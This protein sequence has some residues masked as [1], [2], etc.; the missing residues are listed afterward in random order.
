MRF[1]EKYLVLGLCLL[2]RS[3]CS[4]FLFGKPVPPVDWSEW[5]RETLLLKDDNDELLFADPGEREAFLRCGWVTGMTVLELDLSLKPKRN[6]YEPMWKLKFKHSSSGGWSVYET[7]YFDIIGDDF[8]TVY[9]TFWF[10]DGKLHNWSE[11][12]HTER[13]F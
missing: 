12:F 1:F 10:K 8:G 11:Y 13:T 4:D 5:R 3:G 2:S 7:L 6:I 9:V